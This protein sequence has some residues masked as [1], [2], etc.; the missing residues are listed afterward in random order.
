MLI[1]DSREQSPL[2][3]NE[4]DFDDIVVEG[5]SVGDYGCRVDGTLI[6]IIFERKSL[7]DLWGTMLKGHKRFERELARAEKAGIAL[8]LA[9]EGSMTDVYEGCK[10]SK[11]KGESMLKML[12]SFRVRHGLEYHFFNNR[13]EMAKFITDVFQAVARDM[14]RK[15]PLPSL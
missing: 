5:L 15:S 14:K 10:Y 1:Q 2:L 13:R 8:I 3:F 6:P 11:F 9:I 4:K 7:N 12:A